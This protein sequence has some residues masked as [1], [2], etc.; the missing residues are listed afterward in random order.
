MVFSP[1]NRNKTEGV[2]FPI[3]FFFTTNDCTTIKSITTC[4]LLPHCYSCIYNL[5]MSLFK[6][7]I[8][9]D[10]SSYSYYYSH[11]FSLHFYPPQ[12]H[13]P[14]LF[15]AESID[16]A[17]FACLP[18]DH[19]QICSSIIQQVK[20]EAMRRKYTWSWEDMTSYQS[21]TI[22]L[23]CLVMLVMVIVQ[24][25]RYQQEKSFFMQIGF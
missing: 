19:V 4:S 25:I 20:E 15:P 1:L 2:S 21:I 16:T 12:S 8:S 18:G 3:S 22:L 14:S 11:P 24:F 9:V 6:V 5:G 13:S 23:F 17:V 10:R 7:Y